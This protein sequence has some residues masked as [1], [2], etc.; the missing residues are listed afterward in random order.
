VDKTK[1]VKYLLLFGLALC[2]VL[3]AQL[4]S[5]RAE[6][7]QLSNDSGTVEYYS[8]AWEAGDAIGAV[9]TPSPDWS[10]P[11]QVDSVEFLLHQFPEAA[12]QARVRV[13]VYSTVNGKPDELL[14]V[15]AST[16]ITTFWPAWASISLDSASIILSSP[17]PFMVAVE[18][19]AGE[20]GTIPSTLT[21]S[22][23]GIA[24]D[25]NFYS[26]DGGATW[27]EH[28]DWHSGGDGPAYVG[29]NMIRAT[30]D[31]PTESRIY[32]A[33]VARNW[34]PPT[35]TSTPTLPPP[36]DASDLPCLYAVNW[37]RRD[38]FPYDIIHS[39]YTPT[40]LAA[41]EVDRDDT[42]DG[43]GRWTRY[44]ATVQRQGRPDFDM[45]ATYVFNYAGGVEGA[46]VVKTYGG[47]Y[48][49]EMKITRFCPKVGQL[50]GYRVRINGQE[51][52]V[53]ICP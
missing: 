26:P 36:P 43:T 28:Y 45:V 6:L 17:D 50:T 37:W 4:P 30:V 1:R 12:S 31:V 11:I 39:T 2:V 53:G 24:E 42:Y 16:D 7:M 35:P 14:G 33:S 19:V 8:G 41:T 27:V 29:Y 47:G 3:C 9:L 44:Q 15:S 23:D 13:R 51:T 38:S 5:V 52:T 10:Y 49:Y 25:R 40:C 22:Q 46:N 48:Q 32:L 20:T 34:S 18:Y 21:D